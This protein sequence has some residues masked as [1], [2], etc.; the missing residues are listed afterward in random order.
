[1]HFEFDCLDCFSPIF[2]PATE[3][4]VT[5]IRD[6]VYDDVIVWSSTVYRVSSLWRQ[7]LA[8]TA[9]VAA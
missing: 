6:D 1:L 4:V 7:Q 2:A 8:N 5:L 3:K 9:A